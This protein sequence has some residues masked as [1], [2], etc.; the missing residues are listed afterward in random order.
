L[1]AL[2][3]EGQKGLGSLRSPIKLFFIQVVVIWTWGHGHLQLGTLGGTTQVAGLTWKMGGAS[4]DPTFS[5]VTCRDDFRLLQITL[6][7]EMIDIPALPGTV[8]GI[9]AIQ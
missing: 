4:S 2:E 8:V 7:L 9:V 3:S 1:I 5:K 6:F